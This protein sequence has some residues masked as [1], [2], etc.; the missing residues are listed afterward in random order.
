M[1]L[2]KVCVSLLQSRPKIDLS[3]PAKCGESA[4]VQ[5]LPWCS[6]RLA[7]I[8]SNFTLIANNAADRAG[9]L[10]NRDVMAKADIDMAQCRWN[11]IPV[12]FLGEIHDK[13][14]C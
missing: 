5:E 12:N 7:R 2:Q 13:D 8:R 1:V 14:T 9:K 4:T 3:T 6:V 10:L 11:E